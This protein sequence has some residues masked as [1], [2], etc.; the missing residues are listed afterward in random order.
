MLQL[1]QPSGSNHLNPSLA[2]EHDLLYTLHRPLLQWLRAGS[3]YTEKSRIV[4]RFYADLYMAA[5]VVDVPLGYD[6]YN[7]GTYTPPYH[8]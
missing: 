7:I 4:N 3:D 2:I 5:Q 1:Q 6:R 8:H